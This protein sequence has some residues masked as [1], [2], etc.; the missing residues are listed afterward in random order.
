MPNKVFKNHFNIS[1]RLLT[2]LKKN[3]KILLNGFPTY[4]N[5]LVNAGDFIEVY[6]DFEETAP[7]IVSKKMDLKIV[8]ED[9]Y[10]LVLDKPA[11]IPVHPSMSHY[12]NSLSNGVKFYYDTKN[13]KKKIRPVNRLDKDT[14]GLVIFAKNEYI[15]ENLIRQM[16][17]NKLKKYYYAILVGNLGNI[18][19]TINAPIARKSGSIIEREINLSGDPAITHFE[20]VKNFK[21]SL[22]LVKF[23]LETGRTHQIRVHSKYIN[24][25]ILGDSLYGHSSKLISRQSLHAF[26][27]SFNH[28][29][30][31]KPIILEIDLPLDMKSVLKNI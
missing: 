2:K 13:L 5:K 19:G 8:F 15:Q 11:G 12:E 28:P 23:E 6:I 25:P 26:K 20:L 14:S 30:T 24:H 29:I 10:L 31:T 3:Q 21:N 16:K 18:S 9:E 27:L 7:N 1:D 17:N 4:V 22:C